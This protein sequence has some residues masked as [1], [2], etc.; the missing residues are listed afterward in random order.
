MLQRCPLFSHQ[1]LLFYDK[2]LLFG[3]KRLRTSNRSLLLFVRSL[4]I[5]VRSLLLTDRSL[6]FQVQKVQ[7]VQPV[8]VCYIV[9]CV[10]NYIADVQRDTKSYSPADGQKPCRNTASGVGV[11]CIYN[12]LIC[13]S[14]K[15]VA[16]TITA[17]ERP[18]DFSLRATSI[19]FPVAPFSMPSDK[20]SACPCASPSAC[21]CARPSA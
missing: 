3:N 9:D 19:A 17:T 11:F 4:L 14:V 20:P 10:C 13:S 16:C 1:N 15:P 21:P 8:F 6:L 2:R 5:F 7:K 12:A 18:M